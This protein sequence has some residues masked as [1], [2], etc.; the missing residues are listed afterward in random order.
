MK[1]N[2]G[3]CGCYLGC[4]SKIATISFPCKCKNCGT[5]VYRRFIATKWVVG[6]MMFAI[7]ALFILVA[8][9]KVGV[10]EI[11]LGCVSLFLI[12]IVWELFYSDFLYLSELERKQKLN[13]RALAKFIGFIIL[14]LFVVLANYF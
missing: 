3:L 12:S 8:T 2:C 6:L 1:N 5:L 10:K 11:L 7:P 14:I 4:I 13:R 9:E